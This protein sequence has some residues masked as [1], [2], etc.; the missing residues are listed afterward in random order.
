MR[1]D[2]LVNFGDGVWMFVVVFLY[3]FRVC[4]FG[5]LKGLEWWDY[6]RDWLVSCREV[7]LVYG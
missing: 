4:F 3:V 2:G 7:F 6:D 5:V 1:E